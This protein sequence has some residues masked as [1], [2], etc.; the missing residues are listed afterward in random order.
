MVLSGAPLS[1]NVGLGEATPV[2]RFGYQRLASL[3]LPS[4]ALF[5]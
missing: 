4:L 5:P 1:L 2:E 3:L